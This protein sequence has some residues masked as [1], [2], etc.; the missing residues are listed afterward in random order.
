MFKQSAIIIGFFLF[1]GIISGAMGM[2]AIMLTVVA[3][4][5]IFGLILHEERK[6]K[7]KKAAIK[8][9]TFMRLENKRAI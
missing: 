6:L 3:G 1:M 4:S 9:D 2:T 7:A 8:V 5:L